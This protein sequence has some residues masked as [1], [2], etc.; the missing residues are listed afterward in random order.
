MPAGGLVIAGGLAAAGAATSMA[1]GKETADAQQSIAQAQQA[2]QNAER[3]YNL[4]IAAPTQQEI[5]MLQNQLTGYQQTLGLQHA[6]L[7]RDTSLYQAINPQLMNLLNGGEAPTLTPYMN[8]V[9]QQKQQLMSDLARQ[10]G[11]GWE[12]T[13]AGQQAL[14][15]FNLQSANQGAN[16]QQQYMGTLMANQLAL[17]SSIAG[18]TNQGAVTLADLAKGVMGGSNALQSRMLTASMGT[19]MTPFSGAQYAGDLMQGQMFSQMGGTLMGLGGQG[20]GGYMSGYG[21]GKGQ[22]AAGG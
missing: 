6:Q 22:A 2:Q 15:N 11:P 8:I 7:Q 21:Y 14:E 9:G 10:L 20:L 16:I 5:E 12:T 3:G 13:T 17:G 1:G 19:S 4:K 18:Q